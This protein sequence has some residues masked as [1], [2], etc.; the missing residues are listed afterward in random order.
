[1]RA[2]LLYIDDWLSSSAIQQMDAHEERGYFRLLLAQAKDDNCTLPD[3]NHEL[4]MISLLGAQWDKPTKEKRCRIGSKTSGQKLREQFIARPDSSPKR[5]YNERLYRE[6]LYQKGVIDRRRTNGALGGR[7]KKPEVILE[8]PNGSPEVTERF[9]EKNLDKT[10]YVSVSSLGSDFKNLPTEAKLITREGP[11]GG[12]VGFSGFFVR[13]CELTGR[14]Q[15]EEEALRIWI[16][17][18][19]DQCFGEV[20][21]CLERYGKSRDVANGAIFNPENWLMDQHRNAWKGDWQSAAKRSGKREDLLEHRNEVLKI[22]EFL[23]G[24]KS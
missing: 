16:S 21:E 18:G 9:P 20:M 24:M 5:I 3:D 6:W 1:M 14:R 19:A 15:H 11:V 10:N 23:G 4:A 12:A 8:K 22:A 2:F 17:I 7:P 13:W